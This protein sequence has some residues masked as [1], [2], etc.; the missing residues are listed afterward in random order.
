MTLK[1]LK[2]VRKYIIFRDNKPIAVGDTAGE[3]L[4]EALAVIKRLKL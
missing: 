3:A 4:V 1:Y 2:N